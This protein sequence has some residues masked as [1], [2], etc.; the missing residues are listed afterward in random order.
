MG[1]R[2]D[3]LTFPGGHDPLIH[4]IR[5]FRLPS[6]P[7]VRSLPIGFS[8]RKLLLDAVMGL[9]LIPFLATGRYDIVHA[10]E[11]SALLAAWLKPF[12]RFRFVYDMDDI[13]S[14]RLEQA[15]VLRS[16]W[17]L[18]LVRA[19][20]RWTLRSAD[21]VVVNGP[22]TARYAAAVA[23]GPRVRSYDHL[24]FDEGWT[25]PEARMASLR[26]DEN[27]GDRKI[28]LYAG[29]AEVYQ[30]LE[31]LIASLPF[32]RE[33]LPDACCVIIGGEDA[34]IQRLRRR[35]NELGAGGMLRWLGKRPFPETFQ[36]MR[37]ADVLV[38]P[39][40]QA[41]AVPMK[42]YAYA[43]AGR[44]I[45]ATNLP[46]NTELLDD[47]TAL[48]VDPRPEL[49]A[50]GLLRVLGDVALSQRLSDG[51]RGLAR[52]CVDRSALSRLRESY[53]LLLAR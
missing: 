24:P 35:A 27:L 51:A 52:R 26:R 6:L 22:S 48:L 17:A 42:L 2:V 28:I 32:V 23:G 49:L 43:A 10:S 9:V 11:D 20:E 44:P 7:W 16:A 30:G 33:R 41:K 5:I 14:L 36:L 29:N 15:G 31:L 18:R 1:L 40:T 34:Q 19:L 37:Q 39:V 8:R 46:N 12:F 21:L 25:E 50:E 38:S 13:L 47:D 53:G 3:V 45:V 4:G